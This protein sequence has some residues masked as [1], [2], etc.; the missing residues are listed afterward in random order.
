MFDKIG[1]FL[2]ARTLN[3]LTLMSVVA[4]SIA[5]LSLIEFAKTGILSIIGFISVFFVAA[6]FLLHAVY[7]FKKRN[8]PA[9]NTKRAKEIFIAI[10]I[11]GILALIATSAFIILTPT[12]VVNIFLIFESTLLIEALN[13]I[14]T[15]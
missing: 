8:K 12:S 3:V 5:L 9:Q 13:I 2:K 15:D 14:A 7:L 10:N 11:I 1:K 4:T 6:V